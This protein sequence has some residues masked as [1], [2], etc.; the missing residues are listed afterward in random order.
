MKVTLSLKDWKNKNVAGTWNAI[1]SL[2]P[3]CYR[4]GCNH[5]TLSQAFLGGGSVTINFGDSEDV[6]NKFISAIAVQCTNLFNIGKE[7]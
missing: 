7:K 3:P 1:I 5:A 2:L 6:A 4:G